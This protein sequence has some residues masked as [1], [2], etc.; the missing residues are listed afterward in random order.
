MHETCEIRIGQDKWFL[1]LSDVWEGASTRSSKGDLDAVHARLVLPGLQASARVW[2]SDALDP[3]LAA[4]FHDLAER[5]RGWDDAR[6]WRAYEG[7]LA[8]AC[9]HDGLGHVALTVELRELSGDG[10]LAK[11]DVPVD[12]GQLDQ[13]AHEVERFVS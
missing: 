12:A 10:W 8:L 5:W 2:L 7:G 4:F 1:L 3:P 6:H 13:V 9:T 11:G